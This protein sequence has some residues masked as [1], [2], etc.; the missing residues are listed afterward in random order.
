MK[1]RIINNLVALI[2]EWVVQERGLNDKGRK[3]GNGYILNQKE[4]SSID[5]D[6]L[7]IR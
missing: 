5:G 3:V 6:S 1:R 2:P 4:L 7:N